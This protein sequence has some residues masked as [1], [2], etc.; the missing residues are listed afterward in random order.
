MLKKKLL[1][2]MT[3]FIGVILAFYIIGCDTDNETESGGDGPFTVK[4]VAN[5]G[6]TAPSDQ[7][8]EKGEIV[9]EPSLMT[10]PNHEDFKGW[11]TNST[12]TGNPYNFSNAVNKDL[13]L[14][15]K[16]G[17]KIGDTG[18]A[19]GKI[20]Y[21]ESG[22]TYP[23]WKYLEASPAEL[24]KCRWAWGTF[25]E[26]GNE[27][28]ALDYIV[29]GAKGTTIG[30]GKANTDAILALLLKPS[31]PS[32]EFVTVPAAKAADDYIAGTYDDWFLPSKNELNALYQS[33][34]LTVSGDEHYYWSS[35]QH[36]DPNRNQC[37]WAQD[38]G[39]SD[40]GLQTEEAKNHDSRTY[41]RPIRSFFC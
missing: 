21:V 8:V 28:G 17:Y 33:K 32:T 2:M 29:N 41:V 6:V 13:T 19:G 7:T 24:G 4:F 40:P 30:T 39:T 34:V 20:F 10:N 25:D 16:W 14:Y 22:A 26:L 27:Q 23:E 36:D 12:F 1:G 37:A 18:P 35:S 3:L 9:T 5:G 38:F 31:Y 15:A 11:Y